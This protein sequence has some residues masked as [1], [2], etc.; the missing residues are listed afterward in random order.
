MHYTGTFGEFD[1]LFVHSVAEMEEARNAAVYANVLLQ[2][3]IFAMIFVMTYIISNKVVINKIDRVNNSL[4]KIASGNL[5]ENVNVREYMEFDSLSNDINA[6]VDTLKRYINEASARIDKDLAFAK[7]IQEAALPAVFPP[8]PNRRDF[9][10]FATMHAAKTVGGD[11]YDLYLADKDHLVFLVAD[12]SG[13]SIPGAM[14]MMR[15]KTIIKSMVD[16]GMSVEEAFGAANTYLVEGNRSK[17][18]VTCWMGMA[19]LRSGVLSFANAGHNPPLIRHK[20]G[21]FEYIR[22]RPNF[23]LAGKKNIQYQKHRMQLL[24]GDALFLYTDGV[25]EA[26]SA[27]DVMFGETRLLETLNEMPNET[28]DQRCHRVKQKLDDFVGEVE[29]F[30]DITM[31]SVNF[32]SFA[33]DERIITGSDPESAETVWNFICDKIKQDEIKQSYAK[34]LQIIVDEIYSNTIRYSGAQTAEISVSISDGELLLVFKDDGAQYDPLAGP[35][36]NVKLKAK[37]RRIGGLGIFMVKK[38]SNAID[39]RYEDGHNILSI[40]I[41]LESADTEE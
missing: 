11:F 28:T 36:P 32:N 31:L 20:N 35:D 37:E 33:D 17:M 40:R 26:L 1:G 5:E 30:D 7:E 14:F 34:K 6:T 29:Q 10:I 27:D 2:I 4:T 39:Y 13:K 9:D 38:L 15:S 12:V 16:K 8:Y 22:T 24:P 23:V 41:V 3:L 19:D 18:F 21:Q 25:T